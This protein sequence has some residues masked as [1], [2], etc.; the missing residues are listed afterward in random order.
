[1]KQNN[2]HRR[3]DRLQRS[4]QG[5]GRTYFIRRLARDFFSARMRKP[6]SC[7]DQW[8]G[9]ACTA[10]GSPSLVQRNS[11]PSLHMRCMITAGRRA[12]AVMAFWRPRLLA[13]FMAQAM[14][15]RVG[16]A[17]ALRKPADDQ[18]T[19]SKVVATCCQERSS[20][21]SDRF[22]GQ[23]NP[24]M[25]AGTGKSL[26]ETRPILGA[27]ERRCCCDGVP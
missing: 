17:E 26:D 20:P 8:P 9:H 1:M 21:A 16:F 18:V 10:V 3:P 6:L 27:D 24:S 14:K 19:I 22:S 5:E 25:Q 15:F 12:N 13:T 7:L 2:L 11:V 4:I 23:S